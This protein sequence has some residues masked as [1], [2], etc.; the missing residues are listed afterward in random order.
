MSTIFERL[1]LLIREK[2]A[3]RPTIFANKAKIPPS[4]MTGYVKGRLPRIDHLLRICEEF[5]V[6]LDWIL[7]GEGPIYNKDRPTGLVAKTE[8]TYLT[9]EAALIE[10]TKEILASRTHYAD[11]LAANI[12]SF[13]KGLQTEL[14]YGRRL[15][16]LEARMDRDACP[17]EE[18]PTAKKA[19]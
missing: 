7:K 12:H 6:N 8:A 15:A 14:E 9:T 1:L 3:G 2:A 19:T 4:T 5:S 16:Q 10:M 17:S 18:V 11:S 13:Y